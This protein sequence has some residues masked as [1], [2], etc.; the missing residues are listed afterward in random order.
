[1]LCLDL[2]FVD[3]FIEE[4]E[5]VGKCILCNTCISRSSRSA[6]P[7]K[8]PLLCGERKGTYTGYMTY[9]M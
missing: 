8:W 1:M 7:V 4:K 3:D 6:S 2:R 5:K 9:P